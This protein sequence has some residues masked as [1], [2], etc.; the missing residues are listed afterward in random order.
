MKRL[1]LMIGVVLAFWLSG[2]ASRAVES[3]SKRLADELRPLLSCVS[4]ERESFTL[5]AQIQVDI[6]GRA[7][8]VNVQLVRY[9]GNAF[10]LA[11]DHSDY[12]VQLRRRA[13]VTALALPKHKVVFVGR[14]PVDDADHLAP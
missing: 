11:L 7:Q 12:I 13:D 14:G 5:S 2:V 8:Q 3:D 9:D 6:E 1:P 10:D 4:G